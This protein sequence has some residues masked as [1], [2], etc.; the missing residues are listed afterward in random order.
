MICINRP[1][2]LRYSQVFDWFFN[3]SFATLLFR[4]AIYGLGKLIN[5]W[6]LIDR[7]LQT[8]YNNLKL[9]LISL[10]VHVFCYFEIF[11]LQY[12]VSNALF[13][14]KNLSFVTL[15]FMCIIC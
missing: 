4:S 6:L 5:E 15:N 12:V 1:S 9:L 10:N 13:G 2:I 14:H 11:A 7:L 8:I 3:M